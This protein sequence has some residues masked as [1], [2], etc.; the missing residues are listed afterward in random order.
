MRCHACV[1]VDGEAAF[2]EFARRE[3]HATPVFEGGEGV[4]GHE[5]SLHFFEVGVSIERRVAAEK[6]VSYH[7]N[8]PDVAVRKGRFSL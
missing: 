5:D 6:E 7:T 4:V 8:G 1:G 2:D 3:G